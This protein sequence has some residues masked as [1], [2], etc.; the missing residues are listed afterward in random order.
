MHVAIKY[1]HENVNDK[2]ASS[3]EKNARMSFGIKIENL[4]FLCHCLCPFNILI[5]SH[6]YLL[7]RITKLHFHRLARTTR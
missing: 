3:P 6:F 4:S 2:T 5:V 1:T 7:P